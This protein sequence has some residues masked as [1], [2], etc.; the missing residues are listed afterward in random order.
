MIETSLIEEVKERL[1]PIYYYNDEREDWVFGIKVRAN[2]FPPPVCD[3]LHEKYSDIYH[4]CCRDFADVDLPLF[5]EKDGFWYFTGVELEK[6]L[7]RYGEF[8]DIVEEGRDAL[9][10]LRD[11]LVDN[12]RFY[13]EEKE[14]CLLKARFERAF[15]KLLYYWN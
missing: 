13:I 6:R 12:I 9:G 14:V 4:F 8:F 1:K 7:K 15:S 10:F 3:I 5:S 2:D 11:C